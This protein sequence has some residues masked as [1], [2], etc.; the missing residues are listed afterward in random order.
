MTHQRKTTDIVFHLTSTGILFENSDQ[1]VLSSDSSK[2]H[3]QSCQAD[4]KK[5][6]GRFP[7]AADTHSAEHV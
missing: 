3:N 2:A 5:I 1:Y 4:Q 6:D 7:L